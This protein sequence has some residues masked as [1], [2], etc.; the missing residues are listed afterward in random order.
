MDHKR[1]LIVANDEETRNLVE[2]TLNLDGYF[3]LTAQD[4]MRG[5]ESARLQ[6]PDVIILDIDLPR[7]EGLSL[8]RQVRQDA[9]IRS[10]PI[11]MLTSARTHPE[12]RIAGLKLGADDYIL[13][14]IIPQE[15]S[16]KISRLLI[17]REE[18]VLTS[19]LTKLPGNYPLENEVTRRIE[20]NKIFAACYFDLDNFR[21][22]NDHYGYE[23][24]DRV[25]RFLA[26]LIG[27]SLNQMA[28]GDDF[29]AHLGGD[30]FI[31]LTLPVKATAVCDYV[32]KGFGNIIPDYYSEADRKKG[33]ISVLNRK[34]ERVE[35]PIMGI[36]IAVATNE[37]R[38]I[39]HYA[40]LLDVL[41]EIKSYAKDHPG[42]IWIKDRRRQ[43]ARIL[44]T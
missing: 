40:H 28:S 26:K 1:I 23:Q 21:A 31:L 18:H 38:D 35:F 14:P 2:T 39:K 20:A 42:S 25:I 27:D 12:D 36:S 6:K 17:R 3:I 43:T 41:T 11:L 5:L 7:M 4:A 22:F 37:N 13:K 16:I 32:I 29:L 9:E 10:T 33:F 15:L 19:P 34:G 24:G 30:D 8:G 44:K